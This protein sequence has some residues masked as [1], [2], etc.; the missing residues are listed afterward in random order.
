MEEE[1][2][3]S[4]GEEDSGDDAEEGEEEMDSSSDGN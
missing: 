1:A 2:S 4:E 3:G